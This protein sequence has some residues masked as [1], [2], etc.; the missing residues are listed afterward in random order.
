MKKIFQKVK[1]LFR[2]WASLIVTYYCNRVYNK[3]VFLAEKQH[4]EKGE[5]FYVIDHFIKGQTLSVVNRKMFR[6]MKFDAQRWTN[7]GYE[8][9][10]SNDYTL[11][12]I[13]EGCWYHTPDGS[14]NHRLGAVEREARRLVFIQTGLQRAKL[15]DNNK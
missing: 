7:P 15:L 12:V 6:K 1:A 8:R 11:K 10:F 14:G 5:M 9:Y 13:K 4:M 2:K 3:A